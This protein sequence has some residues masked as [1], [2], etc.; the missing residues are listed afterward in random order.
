MVDAILGEIVTT[1]E[2][3]HWLVREG[4]RW[5]KPEKR[6]AG[7]MVRPGWGRGSREG[8]EAREGMEGG[9]ALAE[10]REA[11]RGS[12]CASRVG[13]RCSLPVFLRSTFG[14]QCRPDFS[15]FAELLQVP[16]GRVPSRRSGEARGGGSL[17]LASWFSAGC[18][19]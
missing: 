7:L 19:I 1:C 2:K 12:H 4:E 18:A 8:E 16:E 5:L 17:K 13:A 3:I 6:S 9:R 10:A 14:P 11:Q 15:S